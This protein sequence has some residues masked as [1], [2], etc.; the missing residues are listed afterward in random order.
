MADCSYCTS[1][2]DC[3]KCNEMFILKDNGCVTECSLPYIYDSDSNSC[4]SALLENQKLN[5]AMEV[6]ECSVSVANC[7]RCLLYSCDLCN[8]GFVMNS[9]G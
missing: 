7:K 3:Y 1:T 2:A 6:E 8:D 9:L 5:G 4:Y